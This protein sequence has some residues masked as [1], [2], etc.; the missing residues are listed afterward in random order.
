[1]SLRVRL[2]LLYTI[3]LGSVLLLFG[4]LVYGLVSLIMINNIDQSLEQTSSELVGLLKIN[5]GEQFDARSISNFEP[6]AN[7]YIQVWGSNHELQISRPS[8]WKVALDQN[9]WLSG[10]TH[11]S[12]ST[13][14][15]QHLRVLTSPLSSIRGPAGILQ[16]GVNLGLMDIIQQTLSK[17]LIYLTLAAMLITGSLTWFLTNRVLHPLTTMTKIATQISRADDLSRRIPVNDFRDDEVGRLVMAFNKTLERLEKLFGSQQRFLA[18]VSHELRTPLTV[19]KGNIGI[20]RKFGVDEESL[21]GIES[22]VDRLTRLV[23][24]LLLLNQAES[25]VM[26]LDFV[27]VEIGT[28]LTE[29]MQQMSVLAGGKVKIQLTS[30][31]Q[32]IVNGDR[33]RLKQVFLN[34]ISNA[35]AYTPKNGAIEVGLYKEENWA[36]FSVKDNGAGIPPEDLPHIFERFYRGDKSRKHTATSGFGL[37]LSI[38]KWITE[39]HGGRIEVNSQLNQG[40]EFKVFL[41]FAED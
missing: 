2:T 15:N 20:I 13:I 3:L 6:S 30:F 34:L 41:P 38:A 32:V 25:G 23:G 31:D 14:E 9:A 26:S 11:Y 36:V 22:E 10:S 8:G 39:K 1:M 5:P 27:K 18:D 21:Q 17:I 35:I 4:G 40:T 29:V 16:V 24:D 33:D 7:I 19:I 12:T 28:V 37:G